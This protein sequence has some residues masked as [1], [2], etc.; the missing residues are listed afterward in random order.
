[1]TEPTT[2]SFAEAGPEAETDDPFLWLEEVE[3]ERALDWVRSQNSRTLAEL[4]GDPRY[5]DMLEAATAIV[6]EPDRIAA[7]QIVANRVRNFW[8][9]AT[10]VRGIWREAS[11][12]S[13]LDGQPDWQTIL[14]VDTLAEAEEE[15]W[16]WEGS[17]C[18]APEDDRCIVTLSRGGSDA[19]VR[20]EFI[21]S[22]RRFVDDG[23]VLPEMKAGIVWIDHDT[24]LVGG[25]IAD[26]GLTTS[27][28]P[29]VT[30]V[31]KRGQAVEE[32]AIVFEGAESDVGVWPSSV[33]HAGGTIPYITRS[34][35]FYTRE[36]HQILSDGQ[37]ARL[38]FPEKSSIEGYIGREW[39]LSL[40]ENWQAGPALAAGGAARL[41][42]VFSSGDLVAVAG[43][44]QERNDGPASNLIR[45]RLIFSPGAREAI[46]GVRVN[47]DAVYVSLL[48]NII[49]T[50]RRFEP[51]PRGWT[52]ETLDL[53]GD[54]DVSLGSVSQVANAFFLY[55][56]SPTV[57]ATLYFVNA[58][59][60][61]TKVKQ[62][63]AH[64]DAASVVMRQYEAVS[65]DGTKVPYFVI[66]RES[67]MEAGN[68][69][70]IQYGYGG[71]EI[72]VTPGYSGTIGKL[73]YEKGGLYVIANI[74]GGGEFGP[75]W[76]QA[77]L[78]E[79]RQRAYDDFFAVS[80]ALIRRGLTTPERLGAYGG[81]NGGLLM[82]VAMTQRPDLYEA[83]AIGVPLLDMIRF[84]KLLAGASWMGEY[85]NPDIA[86]EHAYIIQYSPYQNLAEA[87]EYPRPYFFTSTKD[88]RVH[89]GHARKMAAKM[90]DY[91][92]PFLYYEN[93]EGGHGAAANLNQTARRLALQ[94]IYF[95]RQLSDDKVQK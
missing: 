75:R 87:G 24:V 80:E 41:G 68:A 49:G 46:Q 40:Q 86:E 43:G 53:P 76:H 26:D 44:V 77:A 23:Y 89:P 38:P 65:A 88:D 50:I 48:D 31:W 45:P 20:R 34:M 90:E 51:G 2:S 29:R 78:K 70:T 63:P 18:L 42:G 95:L 9:D 30:R 8:Q 74:R 33:R 22:E 17:T 3:G 12:E 54:G 10:H 27:G 4:E 69:P 67:V 93:I 13:Y 14:D 60:K 56:D 94:Y 79:N 32:S 6:N 28:Y 83:L 59:D 37:T 36:Y 35:T 61:R 15:N 5:Q 1:M 11:L 66:G 73:W 19:A 21:V 47:N 72:P 81:S 64:F 52:S 62:S 58:E 91:G 16:V 7:P 71:F 55:F 25:D 84:N 82:G 92:H 39:I 85:G 57:P